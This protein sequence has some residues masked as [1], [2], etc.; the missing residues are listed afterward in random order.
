MLDL[1]GAWSLLVSMLELLYPCSWLNPQILGTQAAV[2]G[3]P[4]CLICGAMALQAHL[5]ALT[6]EV[7]IGTG[8]SSRA[9]L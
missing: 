9:R 7:G 4:S 2:L 6:H 5:G 3:Y 8:I 1:D